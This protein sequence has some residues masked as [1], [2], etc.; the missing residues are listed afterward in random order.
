M[1]ETTGAPIGFPLPPFPDLANLS[2]TQQ[3][4]L[5]EP[6]S[7]FVERYS[8]VAPLTGIF[9]ALSQ[10]LGFIDQAPM[11]EVLGY[12]S[13]PFL[14]QLFMGQVLEIKETCQ[15]LYDELKVKMLSSDASSVKLQTE[16]SKVK[17]E[18]DRVELTTTTRTPSGDEEKKNY[19][20]DDAI[21]AFRPI[22]IDE[23]FLQDI[24]EQEKS[25]FADLGYNGYVTSVWAMEPGP[26]LMAVNA[27]SDKGLTF[28]SIVPVDVGLVGINKD[29]NVTDYPYRVFYQP[30]QP[31][32]TP[33]QLEDVRLEME[34]ALMDLGFVNLTTLFIKNHRYGV[35]PQSLPNVLQ[36]TRFFHHVNFDD[37]D[38]LYWT[39]AV[40]AGEASEWVW[41]YSK[42]LLDAEFPPKSPN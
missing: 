17:R 41:Q 26:N 12:G 31:A 30:A 5:L 9:S 2:A 29:A 6:Y 32:E 3:E 37:D 10:G 27:T 15:S 8:A 35:K 33:Q 38:H 4:L 19:K 20:C 21:V 25:F 18:N 23:T 22:G 36:L 40:Q 28:D 39:G 14:Q 11:Y 24:T 34:L 42:D 13:P 1:D 16:V 7:D